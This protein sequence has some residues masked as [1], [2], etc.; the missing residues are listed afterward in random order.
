MTQL[1]HMEPMIFNPLSVTSKLNY[2]KFTNGDLL[3]IMLKCKRYICKILLCIDWLIWILSENTM[4]D[5]DWHYTGRIMT[6]CNHQYIVNHLSTFT[7][8]PILRLHCVGASSTDISQSNSGFAEACSVSILI[9]F[10]F[11]W[12]H[13]VPLL[14]LSSY[15]LPITL[16]HLKSISVLIHDI[17]LH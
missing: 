10:A 14:N 15:S 2:V 8:L 16:L 7:P 12:S 13:T 17:C 1:I 5:Y 11:Y 4:A 3:I 9:Y 6:F